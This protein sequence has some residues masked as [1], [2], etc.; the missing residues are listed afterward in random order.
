VKKSPAR[1]KRSVTTRVPVRDPHQV[2]P[3]YHRIY[4]VLRR[5]LQDGEYPLQRPIPGE[6]QLAKDFSASRVTIRRVLDQ[7]EKQGLVDRRHG[8]GTYPL[9]GARDGG[10]TEMSYSDYIAASSHS[11]DDSLVEFA[12]IPTP[13]FLSAGGAELG[14]VVL[15]IVRIARR[16]GVACHILST[17]V[18]ADLA[19]HVSRR[20]IGNKTVLELL[21]KH[22]IQP[23]ESEL[24]I[25]A[26]V[27]DSFEAR[28]L[29]VAVGSPL[30][31]AIR[32]S[33][34]TDGRAIEYQEMH[35]VADM[36]GYRFL[37]DWRTGGL[38]LP[39][40]R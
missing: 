7:L 36:F 35:S 25:S 20:A 2:L 4:V 1:R 17:Y 10:A 8:A 9:A 14:A 24:K 28:H 5:R 3:L 13:G 12:H 38:K 23:R 39:P 40:L 19:E 21:K 34:L 33:R 32:I 6:H 30:V 37:V 22:G 18:P 29:D 26:V 16:E 31:H 15:K 11:Y 27:A